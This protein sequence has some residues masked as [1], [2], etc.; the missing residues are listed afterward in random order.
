M[1]MVSEKDF[2]SAE[3]GT[4]RTSRSLTTVMTANG[5]V[6]TRQEAAYM[7]SCWSFSSML[8]FFKKLPQCFHWWK[9]CEEH[10]HTYRWKSGQNPHLLR[11]CK[12]TDRNISK[13]VPFVIRG[14]S[15]SS[16]STTPSSASSPSLSQ[17]STSA[18]RDSVSENRGVETPVSERSGG[19]NEELR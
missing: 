15:A 2:N 13:C 9:L 3:L 16:S 11:N 12:T 17:E 5:E 18:N 7:S 10:G 19:T 8:C 6:Q 4:M 1:H 14:I